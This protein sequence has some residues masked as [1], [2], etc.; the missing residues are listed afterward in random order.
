[1]PKTKLDFE[2]KMCEYLA[3]LKHLIEESNSNQVR[4]LVIKMEK[5]ATE[6]VLYNP[7]FLRGMEPRDWLESFVN[8]ELE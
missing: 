3:H 6:V 1:M 5:Y 4:R 2:K 8:D 7:D